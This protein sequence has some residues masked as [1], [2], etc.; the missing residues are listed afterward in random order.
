MN[1]RLGSIATLGVIVAL[2]V[3]SEASAAQ[4]SKQAKASA[5]PPSPAP[6]PAPASDSFDKGAAAASLQAIDLGK[7]K[8]TNA[9]RGEGHVMVTFMSTGMVTSVQVDKGPMVGTPTAK[10]IASQYTKARVPAFKG[11]PVQVGKNF[12]FD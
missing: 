2:A 6:A 9:K 12:K 1:G 10:C 11:G 4:K 7:C 5:P 8:V 3:V